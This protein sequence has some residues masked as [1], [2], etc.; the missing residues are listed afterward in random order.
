[1]ESIELAVEMLLG[2]GLKA[3][4]SVGSVS[5]VVA[6]AHNVLDNNRSMTCCL[7]KEFAAALIEM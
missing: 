7:V 1:M 4:H 2:L 3:L 6:C 5:T